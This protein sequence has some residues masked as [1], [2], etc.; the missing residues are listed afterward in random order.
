MNQQGRPLAGRP[1]QPPRVRVIGRRLQPFTIFLWVL[2]AIL[3][4]SALLF[5]PSAF[6]ASPDA[7]PQAPVLRL[8]NGDDPATLD[9]H[10]SI[11]VAGGRI[12]RNL[13]EGLL[14]NDAR[15]AK[16]P[17]AAQSWDV[18]A[19][20]LTYAFRLRPQ[21]RWSDGS[22]VTADDWVFSWRRAVA[23]KT[24][25]GFADALAPV[26]NAEAIMQGRMPPESLGVSAP[27]SHTFV[28]R[29]ARPSPEFLA[30]LDER[31]T[32][33][34]HPASV[35]RY[36]DAWIE[37]GR[38]VCNGPFALVEAKPQGQVRLVRNPYYHDA[39]SVRLAEALFLPVSEP[40][41]QVNMFRTG[42]LDIVSSV[43]PDMVETL[44]NEA[45]EAL[46]IAPY[47]ATFMLVP[48]L[49]R[50][51]W[52]DNPKLRLALSLA[53]DRQKLIDGLT[54]AGERPAFAIVPPDLA[55]YPQIQPPWANWS[56]EERERAAR[57]LLAEAGYGVG[58]PPLTLELLYNVSE[59]NKRMA[60]A[61][62]AM[63][64]QALGL[65]VRLEAQELNVIIRRIGARDWPDWVR[66]SW[67][68]DRPVGYLEPLLRGR[69]KAQWNG[70]AN[71]SFNALLDQAAGTTDD[72]A[73]QALLAK[74]EDIAN[75]DAALIPVYYQ[76]S[77]RLVSS[78]VRGWV[79]NIYDIHL[80]RWL[81]LA[82]S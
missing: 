68:W 55:N 79:D 29:L 37:P 1:V 63:W 70:Y 75:R 56:Q 30:A 53:L 18:S 50:S 26:L 60:V 27:D 41:T 12:I 40:R 81:D 59:T 2:T 11:D 45:P 23:P 72:A 69:S 36:G 58:R 48:N 57:R 71:T 39:A 21:A 66:L 28:V 16:I 15:G 5:I 25:S 74:A 35:R 43:P 46:R 49:S 8:G 65:E 24:A 32:L 20:G 51:P 64:K 67:V 9:P 31:P 6:A 34:V 38:L 42:A 52:A 4:A 78:R 73:Y 22:P 47:A 76:T 3:G 13:C 14:T 10:Q 54:K 77:R 17:G 7:W 44:R 62:A 19:D 61:V 82:P 33:P 80:L